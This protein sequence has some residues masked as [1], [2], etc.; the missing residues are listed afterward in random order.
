MT[1]IPKA[2]ELIQEVLDNISS[3]R[4]DWRIVKLIEALELMT[5]KVNKKR[6]VL[7]KMTPE[8][9][10]RIRNIVQMNDHLQDA[11]IAEQVGL[12]GAA[13]ARVSEIRNGLR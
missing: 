5:R 6:V 9:R 1:N 3:S 2:R 10:E 4:G 13:G 12:T 8:T 11:E 7:N